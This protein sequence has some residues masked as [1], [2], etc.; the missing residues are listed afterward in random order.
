MP[1]R[2][3]SNKTR[4]ST[5][6]NHARPLADAYNFTNEVAREVAGTLSSVVGGLVDGANAIVDT[7]GDVIDQAGTQFDV[8]ATQ[9]FAGAGG[10]AKQCANGLGNVVRPVP[11][12]GKHVAYVVESAGGGVFHVVV[13][14]GKLAGSAVKRTGQLAHKST[15]LIV[16][17]LTQ[18]K[19][20]VGDTSATVQDLVGRLRV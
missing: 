17:T 2:R 8:Y 13:A 11:G 19:D 6:R 3:R 9:V 12:I 18:G 10:L 20:T 15:D 5:R 1:T 16:Y 7:T 4:P 14:V